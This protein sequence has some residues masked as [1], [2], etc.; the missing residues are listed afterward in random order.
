VAK[1]YYLGVHEITNRGYQAPLEKTIKLLEQ[2]NVVVFEAAVQFENFFIRVDV[3]E[4][5]GNV[6]HL[7]E[8]KAKSFDGGDASCFYNKKGFVDSGWNSYLQDVAFQK[9]VMQK[10]FP[11]YQIKAFLMMADK[12]KKATVNGLNQHFQIIKGTDGRKSVKLSGE[13]HSKSVGKPIL[14]AVNVDEFVNLILQ[15]RALAETPEIPYEE[16]IQLWAEKY[17][18]DEKILSP[19]GLHCFGCEFRTDDPIKKSGFRECWSH[20]YSWSEEQYQKPKITE[21]WNF[22]KKQALFEEGIIFMDELQSCHIGDLI[23]N[24]D[25]SLSS[26]ERQ[27]MQVEKHQNNDN[28]FY[29]DRDG[30]KE[31]MS[32]FQYPLHFIDFETSMV[33]I[34][35]YKGQRPY[36]Q[37]AFQFSH[38]IMRENGNIEHAGEFIETEKGKFPNFDFVRTLKKELEKD[39]GTI[40]RYAAHENTVLNQVCL[41]LEEADELAVP[42]KEVL[43]EFIHSITHV[44]DIRYGNRD[45]VDMLV[46]VK[47]YFYDPSM[48]GSNSIKFVL[49]A[50]LNQ[51]KYI[52]EKYS[53]PIYGKTSQIRSLNFDDGWQWIKKDADG[54]V[55][56]PYKLLP[57]LFDDLDQEQIEGFTTNE[58]LADGGSALV[59]FAKM[60]FTEMSDLEHEK[61]I[62]GLL[63]YCELDTLAMVMIYEFWKQEIY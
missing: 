50:V 51:S 17:D 19:V 33:A 25:G 24:N 43:I 44:T 18:R 45:M 63:K 46:M 7:I 37:V 58:N 34:P 13:T 32:S 5:I 6:I 16:K 28:Q 54:V 49:P 29:L 57:T 38:H 40:F 26:K 36:E 8:V 4:K 35:F 1:C 41:Q 22:R 14:K 15:D 47:K 27:W 61:I 60:Q 11:T 56:S 48:K 3:L 42:D 12:S 53:K 31:M 59:A 62:K 20:Y 52:Q 55:I 2:D 10:A 23:P 9:Y 39:E 30:M 21:I